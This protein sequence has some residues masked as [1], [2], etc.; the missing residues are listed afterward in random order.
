MGDRRSS[1]QEH[2]LDV[3]EAYTNKLDRKLAWVGNSVNS[4][5]DLACIRCGDFLS[6]P[7][8]HGSEAVS[9][10]G[11]ASKVARTTD[12]EAFRSLVRPSIPPSHVCTGFKKEYGT[13]Q[14]DEQGRECPEEVSK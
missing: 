8:I 12:V 5:N 9:C 4:A 3:A 1:S 7:H 13:A 11:L 10:F 14:T 6:T 2:V